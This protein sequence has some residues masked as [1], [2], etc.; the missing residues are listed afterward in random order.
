MRR[1]IYLLRIL[2]YLHWTIYINFKYLP[3]RQA[4]KLPIF[5][6]KPRFGTLGGGFLLHALIRLLSQE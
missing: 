4:M 5:L 2:R 3:L 1:F 6:Y